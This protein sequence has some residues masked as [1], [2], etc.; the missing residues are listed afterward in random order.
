MAECCQ[1]FGGAADRDGASSPQFRS[2]RAGGGT[3]A[4][5]L[6]AERLDPELSIDLGLR[7]L[8]RVRGYDASIRV[9]YSFAHWWTAKCTST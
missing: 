1:Q 7:Y 2:R 4:S 3:D 9:Q 8:D 5:S 6:L